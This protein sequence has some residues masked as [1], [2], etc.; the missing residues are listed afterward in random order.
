MI[1]FMKIK[2][3][4]SKYYNV[5]NT[6]MQPFSR[7]P[8]KDKYNL[9]E[10]DEESTSK[11]KYIPIEN[12]ISYYKKTLEIVSKRLKNNLPINEDTDSLEAKLEMLKKEKQLKNKNKLKNREEEIGS[13]FSEDLKS[14][15][16]DPISKAIKHELGV[17]NE[18]ISEELK[19]IEIEK[20]TKEREEWLEKKKNEKLQKYKEKLSKRGEKPKMIEHNGKLYPVVPEGEEILHEENPRQRK[21]RLRNERNLLKHKIQIED[22]IKKLEKLEEEGEK[23]GEMDEEMDM[24]ENMEEDMDGEYDIDDLGEYDDEDGEDEEPSNVIDYRKSTDQDDES[25]ESLDDLDDFKEVD[26][27]SF[28][29]EQAVDPEEAERM[30][31]KYKDMELKGKY[32]KEDEMEEAKEN[33]YDAYLDNAT[34]ENEDK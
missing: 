1:K 17:D 29:D 30:R 10:G 5:T 8:K 6:G 20:E 11:R 7:P 31:K 13:I 26:P 28:D 4:N 23:T 33:F 21:E 3:P 18:N 27:L 16:L 34:D 15:E 9:G 32:S 19:Q 12:K 25:S 14:K 2:N 24:E 22:K